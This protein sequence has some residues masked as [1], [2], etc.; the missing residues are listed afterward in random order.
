LGGEERRSPEEFSAL[1][2][3]ADEKAER[4]LGPAL[5]LI[6]I[7]DVATPDHLLMEL[8]L[9]DRLDGMIA[10][11]LKQL[12]LVRGVKSISLSTSAEPSQS[13]IKRVA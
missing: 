3:E 2:K 12:L 10:R 5:E 7:G 6:E 9:I 4:E 8:A 1:R 11:C 13:R